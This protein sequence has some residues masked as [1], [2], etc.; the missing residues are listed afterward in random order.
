MIR[1]SLAGGCFCVQCCFRFERSLKHCVG[2]VDSRSCVW[3]C[4][5]SGKTGSD[6][7]DLS[8]VYGCYLSV[9]NALGLVILEVPG[10]PQ[11]ALRGCSFGTKSHSVIN[12]HSLQHKDAHT[13]RV[14][15]AALSQGGDK[16]D[17]PRRA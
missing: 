15:N 12:H 11:R 10:I 8:K 3:G 14:N 7:W 5:L 13:Y 17:V 6:S 4:G 2:P 9:S 16:G 1:S